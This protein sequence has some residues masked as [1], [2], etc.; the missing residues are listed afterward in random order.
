MSPCAFDSR[1]SPSRPSSHVLVETRCFRPVLHAA[2]ILGLAVPVSV[3]AADPPA[4]AAPTLRGADLFALAKL[5]EH[6]FESVPD[7]SQLN[8]DRIV[9]FEENPQFVYMAGKTD[10]A[11]RRIVLLKPRTFVVEDRIQAP[12]D[13]APVRWELLVRGKPEVDG[14]SFGASVSGGNLSGETLLPKNAALRHA[15]ASSDEGASPKHT[16][17][18][19]A[20]AIGREARFLSVFQVGRPNEE[21]G[22][23]QC[24]VTGDEGGS[25]LTVSTAAQTLK[26]SLPTLRQAAGKIAID[27]ADGQSLV[28]K[29]LLPSGIMPHGEEGVRLMRRWD[30]PYQRERMPGWDTGRVAPELK[31]LVEQEPGKRGRAVVLGCGTGTNAIYLAGKGFD[32]TGVDVAPSALIHAEEK[33]REAGV[34]VQWVVADVLALPEM[35]P[36]DLVFDRGCY[37]HVRQYNAAGYVQSVCGISRPGTRLLLLAGSAKEERRSGPPKIKEEEIRGDFSELFTF[38]WLRDIRFDSV[39]PNAQ[40]PMAWSVLLR[41]KETQ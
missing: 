31:K 32:V 15:R 16:V 2:L 26:L 22:K 41:R 4:Q 18:I 24:Q 7:A 35:E 27:D 6:F 13:G 39:N 14:G 38:E 34:K 1:V 40:G 30:T 17:E 8:V 3:R 23:P 5:G 20:K 29:R 37:H 25:Q 19:T 36:V 33:A 11:L 12:A 9:A 10:T 21:G 28:K